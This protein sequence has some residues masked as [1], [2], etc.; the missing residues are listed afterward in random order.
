MASRSPSWVIR[1][2][3]T[4]PLSRPSTISRLTA[5]IAPPHSEVPAPQS[6]RAVSDRRVLVLALDEKAGLLR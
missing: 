1:L 2:G 3:S 6:G 5:A 4:K